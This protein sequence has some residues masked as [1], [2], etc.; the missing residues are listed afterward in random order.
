MGEDEGGGAIGEREGHPDPHLLL[1]AS[2]VPVWHQA[3]C[4]HLDLRIWYP[5]ETTSGN[6]V[7]VKLDQ[8]LYLYHTS[9]GL[10]LLIYSSISRDENEKGLCEFY[11]HIAPFHSQ[12][13]ICA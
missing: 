8:G 5:S 9:H 11:M 10:W 4:S 2:W 1:R 12:S 3:K 7:A 13:S 6:T